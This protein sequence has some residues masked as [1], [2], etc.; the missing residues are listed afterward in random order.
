MSRWDALKADL[1]AR[2]AQGRRR[3]LRVSEPARPGYVRLNGT[4]LLDLASNDY[5][6]LARRGWSAGEAEELLERHVFTPREIDTVL[7]AMARHGAGASRLV[8]GHG[9]AHALL[10]REIA[11]LKGTEAALVFTSGY[12]ANTGAIT[13]LVRR[14]DAVFS[15]ELNHAS[16]IDGALLSRADRHVYPHRDAARLAQQ[17]AASSA[18]RKLVVTDAVF[19][20]DGTVA[21][22][23]DLVE[24]KNRH[25]AW[26][27]LDE[28]HSGGVYGKH[29]AGLAHEAGL[30]ARV[31][32]L[33]GTFSKAYGTVGA[34]VAGD[35][36]LID[37]LLNTARSFIFTTGLPPA[38]T[39]V[40]LLNVLAARGMHEER[41]RL[42]AN[43]AHF[44]STLERAG[45]FLA[46]SESHIV[47]LVVGSDVE[48]VRVARELQ[49]RGL[50]AVAIRPPSVPPGSARIRFALNS[51]HTREDV[52]RALHVILDTVP[53]PAGV[54]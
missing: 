28:A 43:A 49:A 1:A 24:L 26:L 41:A 54:A 3:A 31:D 23:R 20:M 40:T 47:P 18:E 50:A 53:T 2:D 51:D 35:Q 19:S 36:I 15:D 48:A 39:A 38:V 6:G 46:G 42:R 11:R 29:G 17:L 34:Y 32:V 33:M 22:T 9:G 27:M 16:I 21:R 8:T 12:T 52:E 5:L 13:A 14:G 30:A 10:E 37:H 45:H 44:R 4:E 25:G 7:Q